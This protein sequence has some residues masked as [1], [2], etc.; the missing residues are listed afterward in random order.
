MALALRFNLLPEGK[1]KKCAGNLSR[2]IREK[3]KTHLST[4]FLG[5]PHLLHA[6]SENGYHELA[7][8]LLEQTTFP[9]WLFPVLNGAT[10]MWEHWDSWTP[11][12][13][14][15]DP[16]MNSFNHYAYGAVLDW[17]VQKA[18]GISPDFN[19]DPQPGGTLSFMDVT[20]KGLKVRWEKTAG[21]YHCSIVVPE[22]I[23]AKFRKKVLPPGNYEFAL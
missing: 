2:L 18:A 16:K 3:F 8:E 1:R 17:I 20:F 23:T 15:K 21:K 22:G 13:G 7:W 5:T 4:G 10:T 11:E 12:N 14:F 9:S 6:L 19:I